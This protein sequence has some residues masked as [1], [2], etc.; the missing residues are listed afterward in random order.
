MSNANINTV[1]IATRHSTHAEY[2]IKALSAGKNVF[3]EKPLCVTEEQLNQII[4][5]Y[6]IQ[7]SLSKTIC[8]GGNLKPSTFLMVGLNRRFAPMTQRIASILE[9]NIPKQMIYRVNSGFIPTTSWLHQKDEGGGMLVGEM[10]HF[11]DL[12][13]FLC[14]E[15]PKKVFA[16]SLQLNNNNFLDTDNVTITVEFENGSTGVHL[17]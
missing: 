4:D 7:H 12:M 2:T 11:I 13:M 9:K 8:L 15:R 6:T 16:S 10:C 1:F 14:R 17:L 5:T 3:V